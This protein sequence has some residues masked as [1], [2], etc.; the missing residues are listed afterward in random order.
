MME[1]QMMKIWTFFEKEDQVEYM[2][3]PRTKG[4]KVEN[5]K[6]PR[7]G[8]VMMRLTFMMDDNDDEGPNSGVDDSIL[9]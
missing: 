8:G 4:E 1:L 3:P 6:I 2:N 9:S 7:K 5:I